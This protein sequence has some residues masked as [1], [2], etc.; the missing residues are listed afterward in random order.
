MVY[1][2]V[3]KE[4]DQKRRKDGHIYILQ[5]NYTRR[6]KKAACTFQKNILKP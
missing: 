5:M 1:Y 4:F 3:K 2:R 6:T